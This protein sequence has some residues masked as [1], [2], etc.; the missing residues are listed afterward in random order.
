MGAKAIPGSGGTRRAANVTRKA[1]TPA[2]CP[3]EQR[4]TGVFATRITGWGYATA[5]RR[6]AWAMIA[7]FVAANPTATTKPTQ[8]V[9]SQVP[10]K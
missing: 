4:R 5:K 8:P 6:Y 7:A 9:P 1:I 10:F 2:A 3:S